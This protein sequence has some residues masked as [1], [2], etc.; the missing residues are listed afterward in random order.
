MA[1]RVLSILVILLTLHGCDQS[2][3][4]P[5]QSEKEDPKQLS[6]G[7]REEREE[8]AEASCRMVSYTSKENM[9]QREAA[10]FS[11]RVAN[12]VVKGME[13]DPSLRLG[14]AEDAALNRLE[15][16]RYQQCER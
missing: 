6:V 4:P 5:A 10:A 1:L 13:D 2:S 15:V 7:G 12:E 3:P 11:E 9:S 16:P 8:R 14:S